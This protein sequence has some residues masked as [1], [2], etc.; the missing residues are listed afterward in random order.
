MEVIKSLLSEKVDYLNAL[1]HAQELP[2]ISPP[3]VPQLP[4]LEATIPVLAG[5]MAQPTSNINRT[6]L[7]VAG[8]IVIIIVLVVYKQKRD[9]EKR[10]KLIIQRGR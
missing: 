3:P 6:M 7:L 10:E 8:G 2:V 4:N 9:K 5:Q 1:R